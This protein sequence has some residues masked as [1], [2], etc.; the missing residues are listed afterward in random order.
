MGEDAD[1][2]QHSSFCDWRGRVCRAVPP[3]ASGVK[4]RQT[5]CVS[6]FALFAA[7]SFFFFSPHPPAHF[8][9]LCVFPAA[10]QIAGS[11]GAERKSQS[12]RDGGINTP[13][14]SMT[15]GEEGG[16]AGEKTEQPH[17]GAQKFELFF[18]RGL[19]VNVLLQRSQ[20]G[21]SQDGVWSLTA[22]GFHFL[23]WRLLHRTT[24]QNVCQPGKQR[25]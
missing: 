12:R 13:L 9:F 6:G 20:F 19:F 23:H 15:G 7:S 21:V 3:P 18:C 1:D 14:P 22:K 16:H 11:S 17:A 10:W 24:C 8:I 5:N 25:C 4:L 2:A